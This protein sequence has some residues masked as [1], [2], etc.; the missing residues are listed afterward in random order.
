VLS[1]QLGELAAQRDDSAPPQLRG[2]HAQRHTTAT[3]LLDQG[4]AIAVAPEMLGHAD[5]RVTRGYT[6]VSSPLT[7]E[8]AR[9]IGA[10]LWEQSVGAVC[11]SSQ[12]QPELQPE[13]MLGI[14]SERECPA[15]EQSRLSESNR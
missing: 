12:L 10:A 4:V 14:L 11:G 3:L 2:V 13:T 8:A 6:H 1:G 9:R 5:I 7:I 15:H